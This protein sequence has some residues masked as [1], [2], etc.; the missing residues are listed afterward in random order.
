MHLG[1]V[2]APDM[3]DQLV[4]VVGERVLGV[5]ALMQLREDVAGHGEQRIRGVAAEMH[6]DAVLPFDLVPEVILVPRRERIVHIE[7]LVR[8][9]E[10]DRPD[11]AIQR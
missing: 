2:G 10:G 6:R 4:Q 7:L 5:R 8:V 9:S 3:V 1:S 11:L